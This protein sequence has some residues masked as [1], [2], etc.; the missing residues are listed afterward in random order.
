[1]SSKNTKLDQLKKILSDMKSV[2]VAFSGGV[3]ST[4]LLK[5]SQD[6]LKENVLAVT[7]G[8]AIQLSFEL[9]EAKALAKRLGAN[10]III[11]SEEIED[12]NFAANPPDR[13]YHCKKRIFTEMKALAKNKGIRFVVDGSNSDDSRDIRP[14]RKA[15]V[16]L[17]VRSPLREADLSKKEIRDY[18]RQ[19]GLPT[20]DKPALACLAS[21][22]PYGDRIT[23]EKLKRI[24][25]AESFLRR[26]GFTQVRV[27]DHGTTARIEVLPEDKTAF[28]DEDFSKR[29]IRKFED[30]GYTYVA[31]DLKGYRTGSMNET[32]KSHGQSSD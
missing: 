18:S 30:L 15:L 3:D 19:M 24:D 25:K 29:V 7:S 11:C 5:I 10:H 12:E 4:F 21:R 17:G 32:V 9:E 26:E 23:L 14:G 8:S 27:R 20:W 13:C 28:L 22:I 6:V 31:L 16:E 2:L 1:M